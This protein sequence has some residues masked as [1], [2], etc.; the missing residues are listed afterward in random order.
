M[1]GRAIRVL[2]LTPLMFG[3]LGWMHGLDVRMKDPPKPEPV[4]DMQIQLDCGLEGAEVSVVDGK[5][6]VVRNEF[7]VISDYVAGS[8][9][10]TP[11]LALQSFF[12]Y[13]PKAPYERLW[14]PDRMN[15]TTARYD[16]PGHAQLVLINW[17]GYNGWLL[18]SYGVCPSVYDKWT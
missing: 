6:V 1:A 4:I 11:F 2:I 7:I 5:L 17:P 10:P 3:V 18:N 13:F 14:E 9:A 12:R 15:S 16:I 8:G